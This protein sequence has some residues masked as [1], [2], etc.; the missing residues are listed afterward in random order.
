MATNARKKM[1]IS[2]AWLKMQLETVIW[3]H[4][5]FTFTFKV[6][7]VTIQNAGQDGRNWISHILLV[8]IIKVLQPLWKAVSL[9]SY[10]R[11]SYNPALAVLH[12]YSN[13]QK[14]AN[15]YA[16]TWMNVKVIMLSEKQTCLNITY[17]MIPFI[18]HLRLQEWD[19]KAS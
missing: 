13:K 9:E 19:E 7:I 6:K 15:P 11:L 2:L 1:L 14:W 3:Y 5:H 4:F 18:C 8:R 16:T 10:M 17:C 12:M